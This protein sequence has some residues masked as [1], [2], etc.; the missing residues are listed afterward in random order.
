MKKL[1]T[2]VA[3]A[4]CALT[5]SAQTFDNEALTATWSMAEGEA[6]E[7][8]ITPEDAIVSAK[9][10]MG[11][12]LEY[13]GVTTFDDYTMTQVT[14]VDTDK[15]ENKLSNA[16]TAESY[17]DYTIVLKD[18]DR[19]RPI[20]GFQGFPIVTPKPPDSLRLF[21]KPFRQPIGK[22]FPGLIMIL[23]SKTDYAIQIENN[24]LF[25]KFHVF[26]PPYLLL[27]YHQSKWFGRAVVHE[28]NE[29]H[30]QS[31]ATRLTL[32]FLIWYYSRKAA[33]IG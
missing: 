13:Y 27:L 7:A 4:I 18:G 32:H 3:M 1:F 24:S 33:I 29:L 10:S 14:R 19:K 16:V 26:V 9:W 20:D 6:S 25:F 15:G 22:R 23:V 11:S 28:F 12:T 5:A 31:S 30:N 8:V 21:G 2:L 17:I